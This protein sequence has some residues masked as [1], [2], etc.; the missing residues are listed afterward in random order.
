MSFKENY[1][2]EDLLLNVGEKLKPFSV[3]LVVY[4]CFVCYTIY[5][6]YPDNMAWAIKVIIT[7]TIVIYALIEQLFKRFYLFHDCLVIDYPYSFLRKYQKLYYKD[8]ILIIYNDRDRISFF[9]IKTVKNNKTYSKKYFF[10]LDDK[11]THQI[12][13]KLRDMGINVEMNQRS[14]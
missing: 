5:K 8:I 7:G 6:A 11:K 10:Q 1:N 12:I 13:H 4:Y 2:S 14:F 9:R 3:N